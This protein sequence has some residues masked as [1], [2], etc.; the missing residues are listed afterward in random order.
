MASS[1]L[2][3]RQARHEAGQALRKKTPR[4]AHGEWVPAEGRTDPVSLL[5]KQGESRIQDLLPI[6]Y[7]RMS[8]SPF[9]FLRGSAAV[10][11]A[12]LARTPVAGPIV[13][14][15]GDCHL[16][17][18]GSYA[19][20]E[21]IAIFD[22]NDFDET[23]PAPFEWDLKRLGT[24]F[25]LASQEG[26]SSD[27]Q[28]SRNAL[29]MAT[30]YQSEMARLAPMSPLEIWSDRIDL[31]AAIEGFSDKHTRKGVSARLEER[32]E[33]ARDHFG[34]V[35]FDKN[36]PKL[37]VKP[38]LVTRLPAK[39]DTIRDAFARYA[40]TQ[41][42]ERAVLLSRYR[43]QDILFKVVG[44]GS[45]GTYCAI[46][47]FATPDGET[48]LLQI[49]EAQESVLAPYLSGPSYD[50]QGQRVVMGQ[51][52]MQA[53]S[54]TFLGWTHSDPVTPGRRVKKRDGSNRQFYVRRLKDSRLAAIGADVAQEGLDDYAG[55]CGRALARAHARSGDVVMIAGY[56]GSS[57][58]FAEAIVEFSQA[59]ADQTKKDWKGFVDAINEGRLPAKPTN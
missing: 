48:L 5:V 25:I 58:S 18:F 8:A 38:P 59:Y 13:Q 20:A 46:G 43:L 22:I 7:E 12:D 21:G 34:L 19:S 32:L 24:S 57:D 44:V 3:T 53:S 10:M 36:V 30:T 45:V 33:S 55:L 17:N 51:R 31:A 15:C 23:Y 9:A 29:I 26:G 40:A 14:S 47:L 54:D 52:L 39:D 35:S 4:S 16:A 41:P 6:R 2:E 56:L 37:K 28:A 11:A 42:P 27:K 1:V 50:N 49:K